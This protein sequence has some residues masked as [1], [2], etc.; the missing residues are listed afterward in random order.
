MGNGILLFLQSIAVF[1]TLGLLASNA[2]PP[3]AALV[4]LACLIA[5]IILE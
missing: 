1:L 4:Y 2:I 5:P 3:L